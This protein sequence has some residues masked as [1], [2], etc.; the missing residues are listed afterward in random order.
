VDGNGRISGLF[1]FEEACFGDR[2]HECRWLPSFGE[3]FMAR[4]FAT[5]QEGT[6]AL[7][8]VERVRRLHALVAMAQVGWGL[9]APDGS[10]WPTPWSA[11]T[12]VS[13]RLQMSPMRVLVGSSP[14]ASA[15][16]TMSRS[17]RMPY[18]RSSSRLESEG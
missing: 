1:D 9:R 16:T 12:V 8:D 13:L 18:R 17:V 11:E 15:R 7:V 4:A 5:Y 3:D 2:H 6:G 10:A 14:S